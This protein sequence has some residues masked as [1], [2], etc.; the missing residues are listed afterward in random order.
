MDEFDKGWRQYQVCNMANRIEIVRQ[1]QEEL[2]ADLYK[3]DKL[4]DELA[5][6]PGRPTPSCYIAGV[7]LVADRESENS[8]TANLTNIM[9]TIAPAAAKRYRFFIGYKAVLLGN[10]G[11]GAPR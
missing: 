10:A 3:F 4:D 2:M 8:W 7:V 9:V 11:C 6:L 1:V 5:V